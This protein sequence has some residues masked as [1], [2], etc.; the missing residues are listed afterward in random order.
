MFELQLI[1]R[2]RAADRHIVLPEGEDDRVLQAAATVRPRDVARLTILGDPG[3]VRSRAA[4]LGLRLD[5]VEIVN[6]AT[7]ERREQYARVYTELRAHK[8]V[9]FE[10]GARHHASTCRTSAR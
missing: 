9:T 7:S 1:E 2:A 4:A 10:P 5:D 6:P 3:A 8:G